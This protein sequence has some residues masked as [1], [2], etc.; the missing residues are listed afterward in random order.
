M[1]RLNLIPKDIRYGLL[2]RAYIFAGLHAPQVMASLIAI[3]LVVAMTI[4]I[5]QSL[6]IRKYDGIYSEKN[7]ALDL[8]RVKSKNLTDLSTQYK[9][10]A[11]Y[12]SYVNS[13]VDR[14]I[15]Q[16]R[17]RKEAWGSW[18]IT[19]MELKSH[20][21]KKLWLYSLETRE[22]KIY[23]EGG[24]FNEDVVADF[25]ISLRGSSAFSNVQFDYTK[26]TNIGAAEVI[27]FKINCLYDTRTVLQ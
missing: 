3:F 7:K 20:M 18:A 25:M 26:K 17:S 12:L 9:N 10:M 1:K 21:P 16:L 8:A 19:L 2:Y 24:A 11:S 13:V 4:S 6:L 23:I 22:G 5:T 27:N 15:E 14:Q